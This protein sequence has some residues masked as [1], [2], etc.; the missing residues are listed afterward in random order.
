MKKLGLIGGVGPDSTLVY[1]KDVVFGV[2]KSLDAPV[3][4]P[5]VI[6]SLSSFQVIGMSSEGRLDD[7][8]DYL[9]AGIENLAAA[10][11]DFGALAC[12]TGHIVFDRL[13]ARSP[14]PL[15]S[16]VDAALA[17]VE[18]KGIGKVGLIGTAATMEGGIYAEPFAQEG[19]EVVVPLPDEQGYI[20]G[21]ITDELELGR[22]EQATRGRMAEIV[23]RMTVE[24]GIE[25]V[26]LG[27]TEL[28]R[29]FDGTRLPVPCVDTMQ[30]HIAALIKEILDSEIVMNME[31]TVG[32]AT[33]ED[34]P[35]VM[36]LLKA[37]HVDN[38]EDKSDGFVTTSMT[39]EQMRRLIEKEKGVTVAKC[40]DE[41][42][43]FALA[44]S[45]EYWSEWPF[46][47]HMIEELPRFCFDGTPL[48]TENSYQY[49][50]VCV[51]RDMRGRGLFE[52]VFNTSLASMRGRFP[53]MVTFINKVNG[54]SYAA[55][56]TKT[57]ASVL[58]DFEYNGNDYWLL[59]CETMN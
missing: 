33:V 29:L 59:S 15:V 13:E 7:L 22:Y 5:V 51:S 38:V 53:V 56:T 48:T 2:Q 34:I 12:N 14:I 50:P 58:G 44:A 23:S 27:C 16:I 35:Q 55:H 39:E 4:P 40:G 42:V 24:D 49:G 21:K 37:N 20:A 18:R 10:G 8:A 47:R 26:V 3:F 9:F 25:A 43:A 11:A 45:W 17:D 19:I 36:A 41:V 46:Y 31:C 52:R 32:N 57:P 54:R 28:P 1:Y 6:E 30:A